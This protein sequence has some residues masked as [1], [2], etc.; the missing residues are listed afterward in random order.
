LSAAGTALVSR[1]LLRQT[2]GLGPVEMTRMYDHHDAV[3]HA[4]REGVL[5]TDDD[6][7]LVLA[8]DEARRLLDLPP[9][10]EQHDVDDLGLDP[11]LVD[12]LTSDETLTDEVHQAGAGIGSTLDVQKTAQELAAVAVPDRK[13]VEEGT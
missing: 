3:L 12:V 1:R 10:A 2:H 6:G 4:V 9:D 11:V 8:N 7:S 5:I 13:T